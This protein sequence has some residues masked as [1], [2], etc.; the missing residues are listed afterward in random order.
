[1]GRCIS[2]DIVWRLAQ[3]FQC[4]GH[5]LAEDHRQQHRLVGKISVEPAHAEA[6]G[7]REVT[8]AG[9]VKALFIGE[10]QRGD[11]DATEVG[12]GQLRL[13]HPYSLAMPFKDARTERLSRERSRQR[14]TYRNVHLLPQDISSSHEA[15]FLF[16]SAP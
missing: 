5:H 14:P 3:D 9:G 13:L 12:D 4:G 8:Q 11:D 7:P 2:Y 6:R 1:M 10:F 16:I 15:D